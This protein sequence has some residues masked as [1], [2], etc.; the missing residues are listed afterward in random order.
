MTD[1]WTHVLS[2]GP[3]VDGDAKLTIR[4]AETV[5]KALYDEAT[6]DWSMNEVPAD[7][8]EAAGAMVRATHAAMTAMVALAE[9][10]QRHERERSPPG[11][12][13]EPTPG[14]VIGILGHTTCATCGGAGDRIVG[15][16]AHECKTCGGEGIVPDP[17]FAGDFPPGSPGDVA[18]RS[19]HRPRDR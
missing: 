16:E 10:C 4:A 19:D 18:R 14:A 9:V 5:A 2:E 1:F 6:L 13:Q 11:P 17:D 3:V 15:G 8:V 12:R 7:V